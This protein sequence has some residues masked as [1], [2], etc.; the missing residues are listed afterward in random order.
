MPD[1]KFQE[2]ER[3]AGVGKHVCQ[4]CGY[5]KLSKNESSHLHRPC[6]KANV[7]KRRNREQQAVI[8]ANWLRQTAKARWRDCPE[9]RPF[10][11]VEREID[12]HEAEGTL[13]KCCEKSLEGFVVAVLAR[14]PV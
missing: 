5:L 2:V 7:A 11:E 13:P 3:V 8:T 12:R 1:C 4:V 14:K 10:E 9:M 6:G